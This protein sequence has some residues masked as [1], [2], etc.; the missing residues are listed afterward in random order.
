[1][2]E[3]Q[4]VALPSESAP[5]IRRFGRLYTKALFSLVGTVGALNLF[6]VALGFAQ[7]R[8]FGSWGN[9]VLLSVLGM[10]AWE[11]V[12]RSTRAGRVSALAWGAFP[13]AIALGIATV[14]FLV[15]SACPSLEGWL[16]RAEAR[17]DEA[18]RTIRISF[19]LPVEKGGINLRLGVASINDSW[20]R[21]RPEA[22]RW[23]DAQTL[24][25]NAPVVL[26]ALGMARRPNRIDL[27]QVPNAPRFLYTTG[28][29]VPE[30]TLDL[31]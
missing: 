16:F 13:V 31:R 1:M 28:D 15:L 7:W 3:G 23:R 18:T 19:P 22:F 9:A 29:E 5:P 21:K 4:L 30:Q 27:N 10:L 20:A 12:E 2:A 11:V 14:I 6:L 26:N 25:I 24:E 17:Y 8:S